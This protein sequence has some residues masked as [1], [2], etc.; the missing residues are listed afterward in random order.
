M[1]SKDREVGNAFTHPL[2]DTLSNNGNGLDLG[3]LH[4]LHGGLVDG[5]GRGKVDDGVDVS[6]LAH[7]LLCGLVDRE[8]SLAGAPV[9][10]QCV[11]MSCFLALVLCS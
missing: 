9:P 7:G 5:S 11:S 4:E 1:T 3:E 8:K 2:G 6:V 10:A